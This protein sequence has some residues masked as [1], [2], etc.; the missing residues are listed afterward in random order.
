MV[1]LLTLSSYGTHYCSVLTNP[2]QNHV[3]QITVLLFQLKK[4]FSSLGFFFT[5]FCCSN[6]KKHEQSATLVG[7]LC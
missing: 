1:G 5:D 6:G 4:L 2:V 7:E 3:S